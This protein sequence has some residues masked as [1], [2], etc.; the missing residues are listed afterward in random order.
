I[1][2]STWNSSVS[3][4][5]ICSA[6]SSIASIAQGERPPLI[7]KPKMPRSATAA[8]PASAISSAARLAAARS[9]PGTSRSIAIAP[10]SVFLFV[11]AAELFAHRRQHLVAEVAEPARVEALLQSGGENRRRDALV[12]RRNRRPAALAGVGDA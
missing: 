6:S 12:D 9:S 2:S 8:A 3:A 4:Q 1:R 10:P 7:A 5:G 11:V